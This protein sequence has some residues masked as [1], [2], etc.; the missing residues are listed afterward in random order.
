MSNSVRFLTSVCIVLALAAPVG[1]QSLARASISVNG[2]YQTSTTEFDDGFTFTRD[3]EGGRTDSTYPI[4]AGFA[5]DVGGG[6]RLWGRLGAGV[7]VTRFV[8]DGIAQTTSSIPHPLYFAQNRTVEGDSPDIRREET[9]IHIQAQFQLP[10]IGPLDV[11]VM[12]GPSIL[13]VTQAL[14]TDVN[15]TEEYPYDTAT[16]VGVDSRRVKGSATGFNVGA[17]VRWMFSRHI[18]VGG[19]VRYTG[20]TVDLDPIDNR[21][22]S[23]DAGGTQVGVGV[24]LA[25]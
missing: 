18:G 1:A 15:Y 20:A 21:T 17:D 22:V 9:G 3:Q 10:R 12:A 16:F 14:V 25:F 6:V 4:E 11:T 2:S 24:R 7:A 23:V 19:V 5:F 13:N 8:R